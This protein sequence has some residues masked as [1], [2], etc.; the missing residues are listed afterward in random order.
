[1]GIGIG[2]EWVLD[3]LEIS[4][5]WIG[6]LV[7]VCRHPKLHQIVFLKLPKFHQ[8]LLKSFFGYFKKL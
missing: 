1:M 5:F 4:G 7:E 8:F 6:R 3:Y 2:D